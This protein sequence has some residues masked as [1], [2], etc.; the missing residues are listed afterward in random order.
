VLSLAVAV[1]AIAL[2]ASINPSSIAAELFL[3]A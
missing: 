2:R 1:V 3:A